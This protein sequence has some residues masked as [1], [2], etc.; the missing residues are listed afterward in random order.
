MKRTTTADLVTGNVA[1][2]KVRNAM[3][4][5]L[6]AF[7]ANGSRPASPGEIPVLACAVLQMR[8]EPSPSKLRRA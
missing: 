7:A 8:D 5:Q 6:D 3:R 2:L 4:T 1:F